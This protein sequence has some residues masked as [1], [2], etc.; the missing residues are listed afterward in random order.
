MKLKIYLYTL[1]IL[2]FSTSLVLSSEKIVFIDI[3][4]ILSNSNLGKSISLKLNKINKQNI[5]ELNKLEKILKNKKEKINKTKNI[6]TKEKLNEDI[7]LFNQE[8]EKYRSK[9]DIVL[10]EFKSKK[11]NRI[12]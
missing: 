1:V 9:K 12:R 3:D 6:S 11:K 5:D 10:K 2:V 8:V 7:K 4:Y